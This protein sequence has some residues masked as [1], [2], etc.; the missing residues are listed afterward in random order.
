M[1]LGIDQ[2]TK[3]PENDI[4]E[5]E[6][7]LVEDSDEQDDDDDDDKKGKSKFPLIIAAV[8]VVTIGIIASGMLF[9]S[10]D[11][12]TPIETDQTEYIQQTETDTLATEHETTPM[13]GVKDNDNMQNSDHLDQSTDFLRDLSGVEIPIN[14]NVKSI[15]YTR[16][17]VNYTRRRAS[18]DEGMELYWIDIDY[19]GK[20]Y[21]CTIPF[22][23]YK[24]MS[25]TGICVV[26]IEV[27]SLEGGEKVISNMIVVDSIEE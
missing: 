24:A 16:D 23:R 11:D 8:A 14:Y 3:K 26:Q 15:D 4:S 21:R 18:M 1:K 25:D 22:W 19:N 27:L 20:K 2:N 6:L 17:Y 12:N 9:S 5:D 7:D 10:K 13:P